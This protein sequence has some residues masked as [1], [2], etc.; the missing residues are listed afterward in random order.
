MTVETV[1]DGLLKIF[2]GL[3]IILVYLRLTHRSQAGHQTPIDTIGNF[4]IGGLIGGVLYS[5]QISLFY[6]LVYLVFTL[7]M[8]Q[9]L[10]M[11]TSKIRFLHMAVRE[12]RVPIITDGDIDIKSFQQTDVVLDPM[13]LI[14]DLRAQGIYDLEEI[15]FAQIEP[16]GALSVIRKGDGVPNFALIVKGK[17]VTRDIADAHKTE[18]W[19]Y[20]QLRAAEVELEDVFL[21]EFKNGNRLLILLN[22]GTTIRRE[23][24]E[25]S[26]MNDEEEE[27]QEGVEEAPEPEDT[28]DAEKEVAEH[29]AEDAHP[30]NESKA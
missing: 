16:N 8:I 20:L 27:W 14:A 28:E 21:M 11:A 23:V 7:C 1:V 17:L 19:V 2:F 5:E 6:F 12:Q 4:V 24:A 18:D 9:L 3:I 26:N 29:A 15:E 10:N 22:D 25:A 13:R 30:T